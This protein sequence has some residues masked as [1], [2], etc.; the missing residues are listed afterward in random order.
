M[1]FLD[2]RAYEWLHHQLGL[3]GVLHCHYSIRYRRIM[4]MFGFFLSFFIQKVTSSEIR[5]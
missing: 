1:A 4:S 2:R 3:G 5:P